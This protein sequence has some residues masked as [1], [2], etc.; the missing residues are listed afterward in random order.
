MIT[1]YDNGAHIPLLWTH[2]IPSTIEGKALHNVQ[3]AMS[4]AA[5]AYAFG[6]SL[7]NICQGLRIFNTSFY[8]APGRLNIY[9]EYPFKVILDYAHNPAAIQNISDLATRMEVRGKRRLVI[10]LPGDRRDEDI[11]NSAKIVANGFDSFICKADDNRRGRGHDEVPE[12]IKKTL[13]ECG[14]DESAIQV[15]PSEAEAVDKGLAD[16]G[17]G[18]L[19][20]ILGDEIARCWKQI[21]HFKDDHEITPESEEPSQDYPEKLYEPVEQ[22]FELEDGQSIVHD[23]RG[24]RLVVERDEESD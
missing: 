13:L 12:M 18:D 1:I 10:A 3:N 21:V 5:I 9:D 22:K 2:L 20:V 16:C 4:A 17:R 14:V 15:I 23:D 11:I 24:V 7:E 8:Q 6:T 19:L